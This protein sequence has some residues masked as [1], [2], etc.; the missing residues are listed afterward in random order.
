MFIENINNSLR[1]IKRKIN[2]LFGFSKSEIKRQALNQLD[3]KMEKYIDYKN[4]FFIEAGANNGIHQSNTYYFE[5]AYGWSGILIEGVPELY[6]KCLKARTKSIVY[7]CALVRNSFSEK[8]VKMH[9]SNL[10][11]IVEGARG[12]NENDNEY[13]NS[14]MGKQKINKTYSVLVPARTLTSILDECNVRKI[15]FFSLDVEGYELE[16]LKGLDFN[17]YRPIFMLI[18]AWDR[19]GIENYIAPY[20]EVVEE[21]TKRDILYRA[22]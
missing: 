1:K 4:G 14:G 11:S 13:I 16:V 12:S 18:E 7:N 20:Y 5:K 8:Y 22:R 6:Q 2:Q 21:L 15:D 3:V 19:K 17:K 9:Y 10:M